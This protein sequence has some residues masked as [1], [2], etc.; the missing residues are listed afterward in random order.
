MV[1]DLRSDTVTRPPPAM[2]E[3]MARAAV[4]DDVY[5]EDPTAKALEARAAA[6]LGKEAALFV[7]SG[8]M[9]NQ[10]ALLLHCRPGDAVVIGEDAHCML[11]ES[12]AGAGIAGVQFTV[13]GRGGLFDVEELEAA[14]YPSAAYYMPRTRAV[15]LENTH[16]RAGG[17][18]WDP[19]VARAV[20]E[21]ARERGLATHLDGARIWNAA[22]A[23]GTSAAALAAPF[24]TVS[25]CLSKGLGAPVGSVLAGSAA[26][27]VEARRMRKMLGG[28]M[29]QVGILCAA[30]LYALEHHV[31]RIGEDH[32]HARR[33]AEGIAGAPGVTIELARVATNIVLFDVDDAP[34][35]VERVAAR[36]VLLSAFGPRT[37]RAVTHLDVSAA[38]VEA[39]AAA[40]REVAEA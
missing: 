36:G 6:I 31:A 10:I 5:G 29:R 21:R 20:A 12:G 23:L 33:F 24:D 26:A 1:I 16:N 9:G 38:D 4:G 34:A 8:T 27:I 15:A 32:V 18:V 17:A 13:A 30:G 35:F 2:R 22:A 11:Y 19:A 40:V 37:I 25:A 14:L 3:A 28:A 7:S 39:A